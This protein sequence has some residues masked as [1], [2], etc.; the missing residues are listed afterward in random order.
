MGADARAFERTGETL[1][2]VM[3]LGWFLILGPAGFLLLLGLAYAM[4]TSNL[5]L[6]LVC[7]LLALSPLCL[8]VIWAFPLGGALLA[9]RWIEKPEAVEA[10]ARR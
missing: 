4:V 2:I 3:S 8:T 9:E 6:G 1:G 10:A 5:A 7:G